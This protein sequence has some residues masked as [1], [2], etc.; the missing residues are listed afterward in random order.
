MATGFCFQDRERVEVF[1]RSSFDVSCTKAVLVGVWFWKHDLLL[2]HSW[3][4]DLGRVSIPPGLTAPSSPRWEQ[5]ALCFSHPT[6]PL[7]KQHFI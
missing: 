4:W 6:L 5:G 1:L 2:H 3:G 7:H